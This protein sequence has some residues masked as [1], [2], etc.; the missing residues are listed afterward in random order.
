[1][2]SEL[3]LF[4]LTPA[5][6]DL[7]TEADALL[8]N[9]SET[10]TALT[11]LRRSVTPE[12]ANAAWELADLRKRGQTKFGSVAGQMYFVREALEQASGAGT[13]DYHAS[14]LK[15]SGAENIS[16]L[17]G[18]IGGDSLAFAR[19]GLRVTMVERDF[20]RA[21]FAEE[22]ARVAGFA[23]QI[24][25]RQ[26]DVTEVALTADAAWLD[27]ARRRDSRRVSDPEDY[28]P[29]LSWLHSLSAS[30]VRAIGVK[31]SPAIDHALAEQFG[32]ELEFISESGECREA[33]LWL[34]K[35]KS[36]NTLQ[37]TLIT[38]SGP[39]TLS[40]TADARGDWAAPTGSRYLYEPDP[41]VIRAHLVGTLA[42]QLDAAPVDPQIAYLVGDTLTS[43]SF[44]NAYEIIDQ[45]PYNKKRLQ[46]ALTALDIGRVI[47]KNRG[48]PQE[49]DEVRK[50]LKLRGSKEIIIV[51]ARIGSGHIVYLCRLVPT[52][53]P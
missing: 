41:A 51:L 25:V 43:T 53:Q 9:R 14:R 13:A 42:A 23:D 38:P 29:P 19:S 4:L 27:P 5:G 16:D 46:E 24:T 33:L 10:L 20:I 18:G 12:Q 8:A 50:S 2:T 49:P 32:A 15:M 39:I 26:S 17:G 1:M 36:G 7:L 48:F 11:R 45:F 28:S 3:A 44:A 47:I 21:S 6:R 22:N 35:A 52:G 30:S 40:G 37:A 31:L 34:G